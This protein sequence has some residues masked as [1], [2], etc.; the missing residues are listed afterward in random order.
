[1]MRSFFRLVTRQRFVSAWRHKG[2][3]A[4]PQNSIDFESSCHRVDGDGKFCGEIRTCNF[5]RIAL[6]PLPWKIVGNF[7]L[8]SPPLFCICERENEAC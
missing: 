7:I 3:A 8:L 1:M 5:I 4:A 2:T 6:R